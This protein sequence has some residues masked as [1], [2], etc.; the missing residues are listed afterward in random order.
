MKFERIGAKPMRRFL[1]ERMWQ[2]NDFD[3]LKRAFFHTNATAI[4]QIFRKKRN[5]GAFGHFN[6]QLTHLNDRA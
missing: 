5:F 6:T 2:V 1:L 3:G 4:T